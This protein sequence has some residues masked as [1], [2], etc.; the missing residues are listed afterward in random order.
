MMALRP[1]NGAL[2]SYEPAPFLL[3]EPD[4]AEEELLPVGLGLEDG[5]AL[6]TWQVSVPLIICWEWAWSNSLQMAWLV[7]VVS[8][9]APPR[10]S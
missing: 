1:V 3:E 10:M 2:G 4:E 6:P 7:E 9:L 5:F 8:T